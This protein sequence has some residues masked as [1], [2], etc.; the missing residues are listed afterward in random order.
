MCW[1]RVVPLTMVL[2]SL[3]LAVAC[4]NGLRQDPNSFGFVNSRR[5]P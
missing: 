4:E 5:D 2:M 1:R 3:V